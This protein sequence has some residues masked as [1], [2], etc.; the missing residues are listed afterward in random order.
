MLTCT[1]ELDMYNF[2]FVSF[3]ICYCFFFTAMFFSMNRAT[4]LPPTAVV[5]YSTI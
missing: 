3:F 5:D 4:R 1:L 2:A